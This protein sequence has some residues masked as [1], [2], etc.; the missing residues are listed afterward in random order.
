MDVSTL[1][2]YK[3]KRLVKE[4][5]LTM[6]QLAQYSGIPYSTLKSI[7]YSQTNTSLSK[8]KEK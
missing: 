1:V 4:K 6:Y 2:R 3:I 5:G 8:L 7:I